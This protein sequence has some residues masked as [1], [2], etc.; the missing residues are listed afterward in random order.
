[1]NLLQFLSMHK[2]DPK[3]ITFERSFNNTYK[4]SQTLVCWIT[5][6]IFVQGRDYLVLSENAANKVLSKELTLDKLEYR[7]DEETDLAGLV[8]PRNVEILD[9]DDYMKFV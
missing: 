8:A 1:M 6:P 9:I 4:D 7:F 5:L 3:Q 2:I